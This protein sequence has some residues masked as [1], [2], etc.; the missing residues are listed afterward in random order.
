MP[1]HPLQFQ[2]WYLSHSEHFQEQTSIEYVGTPEFGINHLIYHQLS[3]MEAPIWF[4]ITPR[5]AHD[6]VLTAN[7]LVDAFNKAA[8]E[9]LLDHGMEYPYVLNIIKKYTPLFGAHTFVFSG[10]HLAPEFARAML[11]LQQEGHTLI[12]IGEERL[13]D[14]P[15]LTNEDLRV[16]RSEAFQLAEPLLLSESQI[17]DAYDQTRGVFEPLWIRLNELARRPIPLRP[18]ADGFKHP[19]GYEVDLDPKLLV[20]LLRKKEKYMEALEIA[21]PNCPHLVPQFIEEAGSRALLT[22]AHA[23]LHVLLEALPR[24]IKEDEV[25]MRWR[26]EAAYLMDKKV[27]IK[28]EVLEYLEKHEAPDVRATAIMYDIQEENL[29][30]TIQ[31]FMSSEKTIYTLKAIIYIMSH[32]KEILGSSIPSYGLEALSKAEA[33]ENKLES[34]RCA[35][36]LAEAYS[37]AYNF[38]ASQNWY[39]W[40]FDIMK[41]MPKLNANDKLRILNGWIFLMINLGK[42]EEAK[43]SLME[44]D[45]IADFAPK[46]IRDL[47]INTKLAIDF[48][49]GKNEE[50]LHRWRVLWENSNRNFKGYYG[51]HYTKTLL[52]NN[53]RELAFEVVKKT[54][55]LSEGIHPV[56]KLYA[57][58]GEALLNLDHDNSL[59]KTRLSEAEEILSDHFNHSAYGI[60]EMIK[61]CVSEDMSIDT[62][63]KN[64]INNYGSK[65]LIGR[66]LENNKSTKLSLEFLK[67]T[68]SVDGKILKIPF[69]QLEILLILAMHP[70]GMTGESLM[71]ELYGD[72]ISN[73]GSL[74]TNI[75]KLRKLIPI[76]SNP[77]KISVRFDNDISNLIK[78][79]NSGNLESLVETFKPFMLN[80]ESPY[81]EELKSFVENGYRNLAIAKKDLNALIKFIEFYPDDMEVWS[82][83]MH[84]ISKEDNRYSSLVSKYTIEQNK[85]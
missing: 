15:I 53:Q 52:A 32:S 17:Q 12:L 27:E 75:S 51:Y 77:Y 57:I 80:S 49:Q 41:E 22:G 58:L 64:S 7:T 20:S 81:I 61:I 62:N 84:N 83:V 25:V 4:E 24:E 36:L 73:Y 35:Y 21:V 44:S 26:I 76:Q 19:P 18:T 79:I 67:N 34:I 48:V 9:R 29:L 3:G 10:T 14:L 69:R 28:E 59:V 70:E 60:V 74:K 31:K 71:L 13:S 38:H 23:H 56:Y 39:E 82:V 78:D 33:R 40:C 43:K 11:E 1:N 63:V 47:Y 5:V 68:Y 6:P 46:K 2:N 72:D 54:L 37:C 66:S 85:F 16:T 45:I 65:Y 8:G 55:T 50:S 42:I 30:Y